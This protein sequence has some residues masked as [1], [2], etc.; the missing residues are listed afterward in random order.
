[1][2][3]TSKKVKSRIALTAAAFFL[4]AAALLCAY[5]FYCMRA[6]QTPPSPDAP[7][8]E[9]PAQEESATGDSDGFPEVD[10]AYWQGINPDVIGWLTIPDTDVNTPI[11]QAHPDSP[12]Y[13]LHHDVY[14]NYNPV[15]AVY[16][17][18]DCE[19]FGLSS[20]NAVILGHHVMGNTAV[21]PMGN[22]A[23]YTDE[24]FAQEHSRILI[25]TP[26]AKMTYEARFAQIIN[27]LERNKR[28]SFEGEA[29]FRSWYDESRSSAA[30]VLDGD[31][32]PEQT[33]SLVTCSYNIWVNNE[34]TV[35]VS[36]MQETA[37]KQAENPQI[38]SEAA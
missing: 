38:P 11:L 26:N 32:E 19:E 21:A 12:D 23:R 29:D 2:A 25:Q 15:G 3:C 8:Q 27:G 22:I 6:A 1:M 4:I 37:E 13:Y 34:R 18:A 28:T 35:L 36:S 10:W 5:V 14:G 17:D 9:D 31:T 30:V 7:A 24:A 20:R 16:L 33:V